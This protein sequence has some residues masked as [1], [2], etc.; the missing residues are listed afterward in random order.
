MSNPLLNDLN[1]LVEKNIITA[2]T[3][4]Q[5]R[6][7]YES[8][9]DNSP[10]RLPTVLAILGALLL[11][12]GLI[13]VI[14]HNWDLLGR[15]TRTIIAFFPLII[16]QSLCIYACFKKKDNKGWIESTSVFLFFAVATSISLI[17]QIY[18]VNGTLEGFLLTWML[19]TLP[20]VYIMPSHA[21]SLLIIALAT[22]YASLVG[23]SESG[24]PFLY[25]GIMALL[26]PHYYNYFRKPSSNFFHLH[27]WLLAISFLITL[28][29]F[30]DDGYS[31]HE[32]I[33]IAYM[34]L[35][36]VYYLLG[37]L[38]LQQQRWLAN[39]FGIFG[40]VGI[41][42][43][44]LIWT[45]DDIWSLSGMFGSQ[46]RQLVFSSFTFVSFVL[47]ALCA[48]LLA[49]LFR[50]HGKQIFNAVSLSPFVFT[51]VVLLCYNIPPAGIL[52]FNLWV[53]AIGI[54]Y[55]RKGS[56][57]DHL[58]IL[59]FGL[60]VIMLLAIFRF[61][62]SNIPFVWRGLIF[63]ATGAGF[64]MSNYLIIRKRKKITP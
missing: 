44:L 37:H 30:V 24:I 59:N 54:H 18:Q 57:L 12:S 52:L 35:V 34:G 63:I 48:Y 7:Y 27:N 47:L 42:G 20:L 29:A 36:G 28:G 33:F 39:P 23:Y 61:F 2:E 6:L 64:F 10:G 46:K 40:I 16:G 62:D 56:A 38:H 55:I 49:R 4:A 3:A 32:W 25:L 5:V 8:K 50:T 51:L 1:E 14:A 22:W 60:L 21:V 9:K 15:L 58:G 53:L 43:I 13:L 26:F 11:G 41:I 45:F 31:N 17:A 19:L